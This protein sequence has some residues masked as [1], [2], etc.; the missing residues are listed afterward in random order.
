MTR[1]LIADDSPQSRELL[2]TVLRHLGYEVTEAFNGRDA[3]ERAVADPPDLII[4]DLQMPLMDG[5]TAASRLRGDSRLQSIPILA[6]T[7]YA[8]EEDRERA[9]NAGFTSYMSKPVSLAALRAEL[10][11]LLRLAG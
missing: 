8:M 3:L 2:R 6:L 10:A 9:L 7:A 5:Y 4:L 1:V 11:R